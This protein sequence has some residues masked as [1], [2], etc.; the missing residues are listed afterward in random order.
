M[1]AKLNQL[2]NW[3]NKFFSVFQNSH[4]LIT[5]PFLASIFT[6][7]DHANFFE[8]YLTWKLI[9]QG[10]KWYNFHW[11]CL[12]LNQIILPDRGDKTSLITNHQ[13]LHFN[14]PFTTSWLSS[15]GRQLMTITL[16]TMTTFCTYLRSS[17]TKFINCMV[18]WQNE[19]DIGGTTCALN[20]W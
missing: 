12:K 9:L 20:M 10:V 5:H 16:E 11:W 3:Y 14:R 19:D 15:I 8:T 18:T 4:S 6:P 1:K 2:K 17:T 7:L 13:F